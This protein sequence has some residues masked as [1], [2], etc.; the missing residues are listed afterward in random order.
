[1]PDVID[2]GT[3]PVLVLLHGAGVDNTLWAPQIAALSSTCRVIAPNLPGH[4][5]IRS[6][7]TV[8]QMADHVRAVLQER[9]IT[10]YAVVGLSLGGMVALDMAGRRPQEVTHLAMIESVANVTDRPI[11]LAMGRVA[12]NLLRVMPLKVLSVFPSN[13]LGAET[14]E[15]AQYL[16]KTLPQGTARDTYRV[17]RAAFDYDGRAHLSA[18][19]MPALIMVGE[20][21]KATH[22]RA[23]EMAEAIPQSVFVV[24]KGAG[25]IANLDAPEEVTDQLKSFLAVDARD[26][27]QS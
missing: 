15:A 17:L 18:I 12:L 25:H 5:G 20:K 11:L 2:Q 9:G 27:P 7:K 23:R 26:L 10:R 24:V 1:M 14:P 13:Q 3:G 4:C 16:R 22:D 6:V 8:S 21:N 19:S